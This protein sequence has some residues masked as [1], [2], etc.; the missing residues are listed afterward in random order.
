M[1]D[2]VFEV[3]QKIKKLKNEITNMWDQM[4]ESFGLER[5]RQTEEAIKEAEATILEK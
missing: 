2:T 1:D 4:S 5:V 3:L